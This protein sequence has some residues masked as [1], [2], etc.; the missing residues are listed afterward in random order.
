MS[1]KGDAPRNCHSDEFRD[2]WDRIFGGDRK[3]T[4]DNRCEGKRQ[5]GGS[6]P[7]ASTKKK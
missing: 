4:G 6:I 2:G 7:P 5:D 1:G 3:S